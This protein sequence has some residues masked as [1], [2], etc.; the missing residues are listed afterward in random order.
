MTATRRRHRDKYGGL[1]SHARQHRGHFNGSGIVKRAYPQAEAERRAM[2]ASERSGL[3]IVAYP[4]QVCPS[5]H[6][7]QRR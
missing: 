5:W 7:G 1:V 4:C 6:I 2:A 3:N